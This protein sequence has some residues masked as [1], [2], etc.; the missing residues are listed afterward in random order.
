MVKFN[1]ANSTIIEKSEIIGVQ[2][3]PN[4][5]MLLL[6]NY[7]ITLFY[8]GDKEGNDYRLTDY[9]FIKNIK[10]VE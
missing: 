1:D 4:H 7:A 3:F 2:I 5:L 6:E 9:N 10:G 8:A